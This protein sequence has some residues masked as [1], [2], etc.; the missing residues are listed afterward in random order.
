MINK[1]NGI[2]WEF[3]LSQLIY[4]V[5]SCLI[6]YI[7]IIVPHFPLD[8][9]WEKWNLN[10]S[11]SPSC[12]VSFMLD[13][14]GW[15]VSTFHCINSIIIVFEHFSIFTFHNNNN[16]FV[17]FPERSRIHSGFLSSVSIHPSTP[18]LLYIFALNGSDWSL[19]RSKSTHFSTTLLSVAVLHE[20]KRC[21]PAG[22][23][24]LYQCV[25]NKRAFIHQP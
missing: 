6:H 13:W 16:N 5:R 21:W 20:N 1:S 3:K 14:S 19:N 11:C 17:N 9:N 23:G 24:P 4:L 7:I 12:I 15:R 2:T 18:S 22:L 8:L 25:F 10:S